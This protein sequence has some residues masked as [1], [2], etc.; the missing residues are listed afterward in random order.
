MPSYAN[1]PAAA[2]CKTFVTV[3]GKRSRYWI[4]QNRGFYF[5]HALSNEGQEKTLEE[6]EAAARRWIK[7]RQ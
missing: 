3:T 1:I 4:W 7:D 6:A 2:V 5:W